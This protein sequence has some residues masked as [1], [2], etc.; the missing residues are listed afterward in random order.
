MFRQLWR[1]ING[2]FSCCGVEEGVGCG[3]IWS[4]RSDRGGFGVETVPGD[5][6]HG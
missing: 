6:S 1:I 5:V 4:N 2:F 3:C